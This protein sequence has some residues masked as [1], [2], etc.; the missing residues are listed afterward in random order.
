MKRGLN[1]LLIAGVVLL[2]LACNKTKSY[3]DMLKDQE[4]AIERVIDHEGLRIMDKIPA[5]SVFGEKD[6]VLLENGV[7]MNIVDWGTTEK[8]EVGRTKVLYRCD[9][10]YPMDSVYITKSNSYSM[11]SPYYIYLTTGYVSSNYGPHSNG[12]SPYPFIYGNYDTY[13]SEGLMT[14]LEYVGNGA[15]VK[16]IVPFKRGLANDQKNG[17][18]IYYQILQYTFVRR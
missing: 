15:K 4:K 18:P 7:Y 6:F 5:D 13:V 14:P 10:V 3:T 9:V 12:T 16:L 1:S 2:T 17:Q 11:N 8:A